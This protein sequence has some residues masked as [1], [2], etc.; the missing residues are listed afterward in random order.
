MKDFKSRAEEIF[1][2]IWKIPN[3]KG[4]ALI[5]EALASAYAD[6]L[7]AGAKVAEK[8]TIHENKYFT[9]EDSHLERN[10]AKNIVDD[11]RAL[12]ETEHGKEGGV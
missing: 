7:E 6:G 10:C 5:A 3:A 11:I 4:E 2:K 8:Y 9:P 12:K 1:T